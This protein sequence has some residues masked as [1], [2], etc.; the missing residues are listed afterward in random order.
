M[1]SISKKIHCVFMYIN[2]KSTWSVKF[3]SFR[4]AK[5][6]LKIMGKTGKMA[7]FERFS[8]LMHIYSFCD[9]SM[10]IKSR[11]KQ[12]HFWNPHWM[13]I[14]NMEEIL[15]FKKFLSVLESIQNDIN[16]S[17]KTMVFHWFKRIYDSSTFWYHD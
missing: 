6:E 13:Q 9:F 16:K 11:K 2:R 12:G 10:V 8:K 15:T 1:G 5:I 14:S 7:V 3:H 4:F 17:V